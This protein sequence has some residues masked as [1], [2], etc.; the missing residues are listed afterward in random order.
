MHGSLH[1]NAK[2]TT[3]PSLERKLRSPIAYTLET[4]LSLLDQLHDDHELDSALIQQLE[5]D[6]AEELAEIH[7]MEHLPSLGYQFFG[8]ENDFVIKCR[9]G[10]I[11]MD[12][13]GMVIGGILAAAFTLA[14]FTIL[15][16]VG[17]QVPF[18]MGTMFTIIISF[19]LGTCGLLLFIRSLSRLID[20]SNFSI[21]KENN[22]ITLTKR[23]DFAKETVE[24]STDEVRLMELGEKMWIEIGNTKVFEQEKPT[25]YARKTLEELYARLKA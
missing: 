7:N 13:W 21:E 4:K 11:A 8:E 9:G 12:I 5:D 23:I 1:I 16:V 3:L 2:N 10:A 18:E 15:G 22:R 19:A 17:G 24:V 25:V 14:L 20:H 6:V